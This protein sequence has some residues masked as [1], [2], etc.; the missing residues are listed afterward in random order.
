MLSAMTPFLDTKFTIK[1]ATRVQ[2]LFFPGKHPPIFRG[3]LS[4][5]QKIRFFEPVEDV[6]FF[7]LPEVFQHQ[8]REISNVRVFYC[9]L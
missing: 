9:D 5:N 1:F 8:E 3:Y 6:I 2:N 4:F 7:V